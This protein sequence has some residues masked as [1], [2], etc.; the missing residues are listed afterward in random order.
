VTFG[1]IRRGR[2]LTVGSFSSAA[3][4]S[5]PQRLERPWLTARSLPVTRFFSASLKTG[6]PLP[7]WD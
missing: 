6:I 7:G 3:D 4:R 1:H 5:E 2:H